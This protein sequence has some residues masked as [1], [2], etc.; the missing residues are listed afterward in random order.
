MALDPIADHKVSCFHYQAVL[1]VQRS[2]AFCFLKLSVTAQSPPQQKAFNDYCIDTFGNSKLLAERVIIYLRVTFLSISKTGRQQRALKHR[3]SFE[4]QL[5]DKD[6]HI[7]FLLFLIFC[8]LFH[9]K[10][11]TCQNYSICYEFQK[12]Q[13]QE[14]KRIY[15]YEARRHW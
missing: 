12:H 11:I 14:Q 10:S 7:D 2:V 15:V 4:Y 3:E 6:E 1:F 9:L 13:F 8:W 5:K